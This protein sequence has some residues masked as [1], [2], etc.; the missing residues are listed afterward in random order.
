ML[1]GELLVVLL[2]IRVFTVG[3]VNYY[4]GLASIRLRQYFVHMAHSNREQDAAMT[5]N[6]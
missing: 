3:A 2:A 4:C 5:L 6:L 1:E